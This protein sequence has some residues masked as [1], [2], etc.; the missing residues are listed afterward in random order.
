MTQNGNV[1]M[2]RPKGSPERPGRARNEKYAPIRC[3]KAHKPPQGRGKAG[4]S[5][6]LDFEYYQNWTLYLCLI[7]IAPLVFFFSTHIVP[8]CK[9]I[10]RNTS[11]ICFIAYASHLILFP[12]IRMHIISPLKAIVDQEYLLIAIWILCAVLIIFIIASMFTR[13]VKIINKRW[14]YLL[15]SGGR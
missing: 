3:M 1:G 4:G 11:T 13:L 7:V 14:L 2:E 5:I 15:I 6:I 10:P 8:I 9:R 12:R